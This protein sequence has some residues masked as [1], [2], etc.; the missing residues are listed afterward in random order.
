MTQIN[1][2]L[3]EP[4]LFSLW[5]CPHCMQTTLHVKLTV[6]L[7]EK[8]QRFEC[9]QCYNQFTINKPWM[10]FEPQPIRQRTYKRRTYHY[11]MCCNNCQHIWE[12][13]T[14]KKPLQCVRCGSR[15]IRATNIIIK[16]VKW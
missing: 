16:K 1:L 2:Y 8:C 7:G 5:F 11:E 3:K 9:T 12:S 6:K 14:F 10:R 4:N 15:R 13:K